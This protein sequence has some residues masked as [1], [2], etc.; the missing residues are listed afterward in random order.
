MKTK[1]LS[2]KPFLKWAGGK[3]SQMDTILNRLPQRIRNYH[4]PFLG[5]GA[6]FFNILD[7]VEGKVY[8]SDLNPDLINTY[9]VV[10]K[11]LVT[12]T[13]SL[14]IH[15]ENHSEE[16]YYRVRA[17]DRQ[18]HYQTL[19]P[20]EKASRFIYLNRTCYNGLYRVNQ[21]GHFNSP[22]GKYRNP[23]VDFENLRVC[24]EA[25]EGVSLESTSFKNLIRQV[26][27]GD[28][29]YLDPPYLPVSIGSFTNYT[30][31]NFGIEE[32]RNLRLLCHALNLSKVNWMLH[33]S[34][35]PEARKL[36]RAFE[37][38]EVWCARSIN[39]KVDGRQ[40]IA[41]LLIRNYSSPRTAHPN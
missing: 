13:R 31:Q 20:V 25:L 15:F 16:Y 40:P 11:N 21:T 37:I 32:H 27:A 26:K 38:E 1:T 24:S 22:Y 10:Q 41:E 4:E 28:F 19:D 8:L 17:L 6:V 2:P 3:Q 33:N 36:F 35:A 12:L 23:S 34:S 30:A 18:G 29:C 5:G 39:S 14:R 7:R 9:R